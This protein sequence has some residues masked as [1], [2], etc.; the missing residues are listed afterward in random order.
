[1]DDM[2]ILSRFLRSNINI[3]PSA[4]EYLR[5]RD[6]E[7]IERVISEAENGENI[8]EVLTLEYLKSIYDSPG[9]DGKEIEEENGEETQE[10]VVQRPRKRALAEEYEAELEIRRDKDITKKSF[11]EGKLQSFLDY[12]NDR[13]DKLAKI[14]R[15]RD[16]LRDATPIDW[17]K[18]SKGG[19][20]IIGMVNEVK[21][22]RK[23]HVIVELEDPTATIPILILNSN[24]ELQGVAKELVKDEVIGVE[25]N[26][27]K[28][29]DII[30]AKEIFFP[31]VP[32]KN[33]LKKS[34]VPLALALVS[35][36]H[37]GSTKFL[38][39]DFLKF[40]KWLRGDLGTSRQRELA[41]RVK[42]LIIGGDLVDGVGIY[43]GQ[44]SELEIKD[45]YQQY[46]KLA[47][48]LTQV[49][50]HVEIVVI[51][52]NHDA[53]RQ[54]EPQP[55]IMEEFA[56][57][58]YKDPRVHMVG[59]PCYTMV[60]GVDVLSYHGRSLD[61]IISTMPDMSYS[62]PAKAMLALVKKRHLSP[63]YGGKVPLAPEAMDYMLIE[64]TPDIFHVGHVHTAEV[65]NY[66]GVLLINSGTFQD[67][68]SFQR[69]LNVIPTP[70]RIPI[71]D[72][73]TQKT[74]IMRFDI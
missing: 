60:H 7:G 45:I 71:V 31:D 74:T 37:M 42:Y 10:V 54:A 41:G 38:E 55:A 53:A 33:G 61:D 58:F 20:K 47:D 44:E 40:I 27:G 21:P 39:E 17:M 67:Q 23:G 15:N 51:P 43:P 70:G 25:G 73:Q 59:N 63:V 69:K 64:D 68:T 32:V 30:I 26:L 1:M 35:D 14:L 36:I 29:S 22:T 4:L 3:H 11:S 66:R 49:P 18:K 57:D 52:G 2:E 72:L 34:Q 28:D 48:Y 13:Y 5:K 56:P 24:R 9:I 62:R 12:F 8:P 46:K 16:T 65:S 50:D 6:A 19:V